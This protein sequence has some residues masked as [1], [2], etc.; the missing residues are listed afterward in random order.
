GT[1][2]AFADGTR[3]EVIATVSD[4]AGNS[5]LDLSKNELCIAR[6]PL[7]TIAPLLPRSS[8]DSSAPFATVVM[9]P[10][11]PVSASI[12]ID[13]VAELKK[14][15]ATIDLL[16]EED[17]S[18]K[19]IEVLSQAPSGTTPVPKGEN[20]QELTVSPSNNIPQPLSSIE[21]PLVEIGAPL[22]MVPA[23]EV[24]I[25][26]VE[27]HSVEINQ[28]IEETAQN[29]HDTLMLQRK[30]PDQQLDLIDLTG[31]QFKYTVPSDTF[32]HSDQNAIVTLNAEQVDGQPLPGWLSFNPNSGLFVGIPPQGSQVDLMIKVIANDANGHSADSVFRIHIGNM[33][34]VTPQPQG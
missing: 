4:A 20:Q 29:G 14:E 25:V 19:L 16:E 10:Q 28:A 26:S 7:S 21:S 23:E 34:S 12:A 33:N 13:V 9:A 8:F 32:V 5:T 1:T 3:Y 6:V 11:Q 24:A 27:L 30:I 2:A 17:L 15:T 18:Q 22:P 31:A